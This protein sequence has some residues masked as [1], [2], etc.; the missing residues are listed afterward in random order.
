MDGVCFCSQWCRRWWPRWGLRWRLCS[1]VWLMARPSCRRSAAPACEKQA[2]HNNNMCM[3]RAAKKPHTTLLLYIHVQTGLSGNV[4]NEEQ[5]CTSGLENQ[6][7]SLMDTTCFFFVFIANCSSCPFNAQSC[8]GPFVPLDNQI[9]H[10]Y[11]CVRVIT[12]LR[13]L[14]YLGLFIP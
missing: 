1:C 8:A 3:L 11:P 12:Q 5:M 13:H 7:N 2:A 9:M 6:E 4:D 10:L 14:I